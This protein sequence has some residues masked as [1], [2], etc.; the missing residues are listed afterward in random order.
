MPPRRHLL[1]IAFLTVLT[2]IVLV[3]RTG[4]RDGQRGGWLRKGGPEEDPTP[5]PTPC[6]EHLGWLDQYQFNYPIQYVS[7]K[8]ITSTSPTHDRPSLSIQEYPLF[9]ESTA[10]DLAE[11]A[12]VKIEKCLP[13]LELDVPHG[14]LRPADASNLVF[15]LQTTMSRL[16][17]TV[18]HLARWLPHTGA[19]LYAIVIE[20]E[21]TPADDR[22]MEKVQKKFKEAGM[23]VHLIH[24]VREDH[25]FAQRYFSLVSVMYRM[26]NAKTQWVITIDDDTFFPSIHELLALLSKYDASRP[27]YLGAL[28]EDWWA[29]NRYGLMGFGGA[30][31]MISLPLAQTIANHTEDCEEHLRTS[32]GDISVMDCIYAHS[33]TK[34]THIP[35][36]HQV[37]MHGD[38]SGFYESGRELLS[39]HHWK[40]SVGYKL[41][42]DKMH[43]VSDVCETCFLQRW[44]FPNDLVLTNGFS[45]VHYPQG[46]I[47]GTK[48]GVLGGA[49]EK[50]DLNEVERTWG[51][52]INVLHSLAPT[53]AKMEAESKTSYRLLDSQLVDAGDGVKDT[54][55]Q[56]YF[57]KGEK[58][59]NEGRDTVMVLDWK[60]GPNAGPDDVGVMTEETKT[61]NEQAKKRPHGIERFEGKR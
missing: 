52:D 20:N 21:E 13:P 57:R 1:L 46:H 37:D 17:D 16:K 47:S 26:R 59:V 50:V 14:R 32:A 34:L 29:V 6:V 8:I 2:L 15:G 10:I 23:N 43:L 25:T 48:P 39:L 22:E 35:S 58:G 49:I 31:I 44:Q 60:A 4:S 24:P 54:V 56:V 53:R 38:L 9:D 19:R 7:R 3:A 18:K 51:D 30:G 12:T 41:E 5:K 33:L 36:L 61:K 55:R 40:E 45:I 11:S 42:L 27:Y 28:S